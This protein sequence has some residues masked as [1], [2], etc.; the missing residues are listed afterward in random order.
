MLINNAGLGHTEDFSTSPFEKIE[1]LIN[2]NCLA[3]TKLTRLFG[4]QMANRGKALSLYAPPQAFTMHFL[5][6]TLGPLL[7]VEGGSCPFRP[8]QAQPRDLVSPLTRPP[9]LTLRHSR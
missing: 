8:S 2:V 5:L 6:N 3:L 1:E 9:R 7:Q 4:A